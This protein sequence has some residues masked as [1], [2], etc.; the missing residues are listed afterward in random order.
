[1]FDWFL[2]LIYDDVHALRRKSEHAGEEPEKK[3]EKPPMSLRE[4]TAPGS[5]VRMF[6]LLFFIL[7]LIAIP[8]GL[9]FLFQTFGFLLTLGIAAGVFLGFV[10]ICILINALFNRC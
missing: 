2:W 4:L 10:L 1:M 5:T 7:L 8:I 6:G 9:L 3:P